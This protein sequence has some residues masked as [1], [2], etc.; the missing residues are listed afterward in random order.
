MMIVTFAVEQLK[1]AL[2]IANYAS[3][4]GCEVINIHRDEW[5]VSRWQ[6]KGYRVWVN[7][8]NG[9]MARE[10]E[11]NIKKHYGDADGLSTLPTV[12]DLNK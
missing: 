5:I 1:D 10:L 3:G 6:T 12:V 8:H 7:A 2:G 9:I 11:N 4:F